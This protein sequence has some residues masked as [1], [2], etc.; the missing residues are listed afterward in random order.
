MLRFERAPGI[1]L[2]LEL[3][4]NGWRIGWNSEDY[5]DELENAVREA[6]EHSNEPTRVG[7]S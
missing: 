5:L 2:G 1:G 7:V 3:R 4:G 6:L